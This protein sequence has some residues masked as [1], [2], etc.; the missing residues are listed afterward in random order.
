[1]GVGSNG[2]KKIVF[3]GGTKNL[4]LFNLDLLDK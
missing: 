4:K 2:S 1:M 3:R